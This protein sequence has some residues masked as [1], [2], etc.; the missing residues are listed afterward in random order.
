MTEEVENA[1]VRVH[2]TITST[3]R[4]TFADVDAGGDIMLKV[5]VSCPSHCDLQGRQIR[6]ADEA[7][8]I[9]M[10]LDLKSFDGAANETGEFV[11]KAPNKP[12]KYTWTTVFAAQGKEGILHEESSSSFSFMVRPHETSLAV[13]DVPSP[14]VYNAGFN[15]KVGVRCSV[16]CK[17]NGQKVEIYDDQ[18]ALVA[19]GILGDLPWATSG[20]LYWV[21]V[22]LKAP[23][24]GEFY[25][26]TAKFPKPGL[27]LEHEGTALTFAFG[28]ASPPEHIV[29]VEVID[30]YTRT[31]IENAQVT[32]HSS[33]TPYGNQTDDA[34]V[35]KLNVPKGKYQIYVYK[36]FYEDLQIA[37]DVSSDLTIK[38]EL[39]PAPDG[40]A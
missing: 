29:T 27:E 37:A 3:D 1:E 24:K 8:A 4:S 20:A 31:P 36:R 23:S 33:G 10:E 35:T 2:E 18:G 13:W 9:V 5:K 15:L 16:A 38:A 11:V 30:L 26:W 25:Q 14:V 7:G 32:L 21:E 22:A 28:T 12:G 39:L 17:L 40:G 19:T 34:G 6:I